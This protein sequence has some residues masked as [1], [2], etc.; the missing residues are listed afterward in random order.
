MTTPLQTNLEL[1]EWQKKFNPTQPVNA[2]LPAVK[3]NGND[4]KIN[5][6]YLQPGFFSR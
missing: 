5:N 4:K 6:K 3:R 2:P 1:R